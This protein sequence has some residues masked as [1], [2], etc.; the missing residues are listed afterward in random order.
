L[1][2]LGQLGV[3]GKSWVA[4]GL[5]RKRVFRHLTV[6]KKGYP[7][8]I[9]QEGKVW[10]GRVKGCPAS[11]LFGGGGNLREDLSGR[12]EDRVNLNCSK[13]CLVFLWGGALKKILR[14]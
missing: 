7:Y 12:E 2:G 14:R 11:A 1:I 3:G 8:A 10:E 13:M 4:V 9:C 6:A 5:L